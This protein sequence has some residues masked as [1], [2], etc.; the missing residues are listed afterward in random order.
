MD[1]SCLLERVRGSL[2]TNLFPSQIKAGNSESLWRRE[3]KTLY[4]SRKFSF[5]L[6]AGAGAQNILF[7]VFALVSD[8][9]KVIF[10]G[11]NPDISSVSVE[12]RIILSPRAKTAAVARLC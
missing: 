7:T 5:Y 9:L 12:E 6:P 10:V 11:G 2:G 8:P 4:I 1:L 3:H